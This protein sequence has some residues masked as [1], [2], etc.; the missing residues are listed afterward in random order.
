MAINPIMMT[1]TD[2]VNS[3]IDLDT[4]DV[5]N[6]NRQ[7]LFRKEHVGKSKALVAKESAQAF[8]PD[9]NIIAHHGNIMVPEYGVDFF[10]KFN[11][12]MNALDNRAARNHVN[13]MCLAA[14]VPLIE[15]G[16][17]GYLGQ[18]DVIKKGKTECYECQPKAAQ[19][20]FPGCTIR[21]TPS[22]PIHCIVW[23]KH[24]FNQLFGED[25][26]DQEVSPDTED[27]EAAGDA[28]QSALSAEAEKDV[29]GGIKRKSTRV[30][31]QEIGYDPAKLFNKF[32]RDD[33]KY[34]LSMENLWKKR[35]PP[36]AQ[37]WNEV[38]QHSTETSLESESGLQDQRIWSMSECALMF[39]KSISQLKA[40]LAARG[41]GGMLV[42]DKDDE[43]AMN[44]VTATANIRAHIY[45]IVTKS[46]F[47]IKSMAGNIIPAIATTN[48][49]IAALIVMEGLKIL[50]GNFEKCRNV[51]LT[52][53]PNFRKR[54]LVP[55]TLNPPN[56]KCYVCCEKPEVVVKLNPKHVTVKILEDKI[57]KGGLNMVAPDVEVDDGKGTILISSEEGETDDNHDKPLAT[58]N[59]GDGTRLKCDDF[60]QAYEVVITIKEVEKLENEA[61]FEIV[62][63]LESLLDQ[64]AEK[65]DEQKKAESKNGVVAMEDEDVV[66]ETTPTAGTKR[67]ASQE[68]VSTPKKPRHDDDV[69]VL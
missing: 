52:R 6:L 35:R 2:L 67:K 58:F 42:W 59:I 64:V 49:I 31:S 5:S 45:G 29:A 9:A 21:N 53:Q 41:D 27:P 46:R 37:D 16:T 44:F 23:A 24:L 17:A 4:I 66:M 38:C 61:E 18:V 8:N 3:K 55:C 32:F 36:V 65:T 51:F 40:D 19:K 30:W 7:F 22:E 47:E 28:G 50:S 10:K 48:A 39:G 57:L 13:R 25:D 14:D 43:A 26:P 33:V 20:T 11:V 34:L 60:L 56:P 54:L 12:V 63:D 62:G 68:I 69:I 1:N 15:S